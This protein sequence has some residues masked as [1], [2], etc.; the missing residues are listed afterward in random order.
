MAGCTENSA[1]LLLLTMK[2]SAW[3][4]SSAGPPLIS[5]AHAVTVCAPL[6][7][8]A[9]WLA[10]LVKLGASLTAVTVTVKVCVALVSMPPLA[11]PPLSC[12][13]T[14]TVA[15]PLALAAGVNDSV[16]LAAT[17]GCA[18]NSALLLL[19]TMKFS[20]WPL[21]S[22]GPALMLVAQA[23]R[24]CAPASSATVWLAPMVKLGA[25]LTEAI[26]TV[27]VATL[28]SSDALLARNVNVSV[29]LAFAFGV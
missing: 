19:L 1:L 29:P 21:S 24:V 23:A 25:S 3:P 7:W 17:A 6:S 5:V 27:T 14:V 22:A 16:P 28:L 18:E 26:V 11:T 15:E 10:P 4:L 20:A 8:V 9:D 12:S 13:C 2:F